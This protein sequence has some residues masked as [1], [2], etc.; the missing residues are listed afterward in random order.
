MLLQKTN[1]KKQTM[2]TLLQRIGMKT[3][4]GLAAAL[5][6]VVG[7][8]SAQANNLFGI[9][10]S[11][12][13][14]SIN[15]SSAHSCG[16]QYGFA[17][18]TE[19]TYFQDAYFNGNMNNGKAAGVQMGAYDFCRPD[20]YS[21]ATEANYFWGFAGGKIAPDGK[22]LYPMA[23][24]EVFNG[25]VGAANYT[26]WFNAWSSTVKGKTSHFLHPVI[27]CSAGNGACDLIEYDQP[28]G[29][30]LSAW[31]ANYNGQ[32]LYTGNPWTCCTCCNAW[33]QGCGGSNWTYW[34]VS[35]TG[36][37]CGISGNTDFDAYPLSLSELI[38]YQGVK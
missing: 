31:I 1:R 12:Y 26:A 28:G 33:Q 34:Q 25:H 8:Q 9:D 11:S 3:S 30:Y 35:S 27:Y 36:S 18:A 7:A 4:L 24:F 5:A 32:N 37:L 17:K 19:G 16:A 21:P 15:W 2:K 38:A 14:G 10:V 20:L 23:D 6:L 29:I 22:S 13:Q